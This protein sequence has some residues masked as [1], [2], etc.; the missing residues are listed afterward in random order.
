MNMAL[1]AV[2]EIFA[3]DDMILELDA[4][5][6]VTEK[7]NLIR[8]NRDFY[9]ELSIKLCTGRIALGDAI[10]EDGTVNIARMNFDNMIL[11]NFNNE[12]NETL[13]L[14]P[15]ISNEEISI[16]GHKY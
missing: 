3:A 16:T 6:V 11:N 5:I 13:K 15:D 10:N 7:S 9:Y 2:A 1:P 12:V 4:C 8:V 14:A